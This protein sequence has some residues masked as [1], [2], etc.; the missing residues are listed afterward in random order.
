MSKSLKKNISKINHS[1][2]EYFQTKV[3]LIKLSLLEKS[4]RLVAYLI[5]VWV[6]ISLLIWI[7]GFAVAAFAIWYGKIYDNFTVGLL[8]ASGVMLLIAFLFMVFRK[9][10]VTTLVLQHFSKILLD[11][12]NNEEI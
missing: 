12:E 2:K 9:N 11:D 7:L 8:I 5:N 6:L 3:D 10:I 1:A 4:T